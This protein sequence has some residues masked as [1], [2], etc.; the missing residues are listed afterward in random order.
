ML[1]LNAIAQTKTSPQPPTPR[2]EDYPITEVFRGTPAAPVLATPQQRLFR[3]MIRTGGQ[4]AYGD[5]KAEPGPNFAGHYIIV[6][7]NCGSPC[8][9][10]AIV[11]AVTG[12]VY[13][14]PM[15]NNLQMSWLDGGP[16]LPQVQFR[17]NSRLVIMT[18][19]PAMA[20]RPIFTHYFLW[21]DNQWILLRKVPCGPKGSPT[22]CD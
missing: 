4:G 7:W 8:T 17:R 6:T 9:M 20:K 18:P 16:W 10:M 21:K 3:T 12:T 15:T 11:D 22:G 13:N 1:A 2:F 14:S 19:V 5:G